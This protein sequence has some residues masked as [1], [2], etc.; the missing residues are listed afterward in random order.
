MNL[1]FLVEGFTESGF[2]PKFLEFYFD[3]AFKRVDFACDAKENN[4]YLLNSGGCDFLY[5]GSQIPKDDDACLK[6]AIKE[7]NENPVFDY[8]IICIDAD[9]F[10]IEERKDEFDKYIKKYTKE[11]ISLSKSCTF[12]LVIQ[13]RCLETWFLGNEKM[14]KQN[15]ANE[16]YISYVKYYNVKQGDPE[17]MGNYSDKFTHQDFHLQ[18]LRK[19]LSEKKQIYKKETP[20][21]ILNVKYLNELEKRSTKKNKHLQTFAQFVTFC[22]EIKQKLT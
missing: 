8:L 11:N 7:I 20:D 18:Y 6:N 1:Y 12:Q 22:K 2:Y 13:N 15:P 3:N 19:M 17:K 21:T 14:F 9:E 4:Y 16:P 5:T 10:S